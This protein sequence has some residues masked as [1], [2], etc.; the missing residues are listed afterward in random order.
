MD[1]NIARTLCAVGISP[2]VEAAA[3]IVEE[4]TLVCRIGERSYDVRD[5]A[6]VVEACIKDPQF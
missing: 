3:K 6:W 2:S 4:Y 1:I 5:H